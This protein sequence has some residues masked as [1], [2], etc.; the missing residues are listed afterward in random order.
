[1]RQSAEAEANLEAV[2]I[3]EAFR[4]RGRRRSL[5]LLAG[6]NRSPLLLR[7]SLVALFLFAFLRWLNCGVFTARFMRS[8]FP[9]FEEKRRR[10]NSICGK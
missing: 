5:V 10:R 2:K 1:M 8:R 9:Y 3:S 6:K 4:K 7:L